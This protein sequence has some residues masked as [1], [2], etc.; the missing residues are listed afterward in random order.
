M[1]KSTILFLE[2]LTILAFVFTACEL[3]P[4]ES[5]VEV[6]FF[7]PYLTADSNNPSRA[8]SS[9]SSGTS[10][11]FTCVFEHEN[12]R[13]FSL[14][15]NSGQTL[16]TGKI[17]AGKWSITLEAFNGSTREYSAA[18]K[19]TLA[20]NV[21]QTLVFSFTKPNGSGNNSGNSGDIPLSGGEADINF[22][23]AIS[24]RT[25]VSILKVSLDGIDDIYLSDSS[26]K[27]YNENQNIVSS[28]NIPENIT[29]EENKIV[30]LPVSLSKGTYTVSLFQGTRRRFIS[31]T[32]TVYPVSTITSVYIPNASQS[33]ASNVLPVTISGTNLTSID[34]KQNL[35]TI[36]GDITVLSNI[37]VIDDSKITATII[38]PSNEI[39]E[40][41]NITVTY[42]NQ[43]SISTSF[44]VYDDEK[45]F[46]NVG[47]FLLN[48]GTRIEY[49]DG[50]T[51]TSE[52][53]EKVIAIVGAKLY[54]G[55]TI[56]AT[57]INLSPTSLSLENNHGSFSYEG[58]TSAATFNNSTYTITGD[59]QG[60]DNLEYI[61][62]QDENGITDFE[63]NYPAFYYT[64]NYG[65]EQN[66]SG[67]YKKNWY[68]PSIYE[69]SEIMKNAAI[70]ENA[71]VAIDKSKF[72]RS[73]SKTQ[74]NSGTSSA[75]YNYYHYFYIL[76]SSYADNNNIFVT[77]VS[78]T[79]PE[80]TSYS[81]SKFDSTCKVPQSTTNYNSLSYTTNI[82]PFT[83]DAFKGSYSNSTGM[84]NY[85]YY[86]TINVLP[87]HIVP[88]N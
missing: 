17:P 41:Q 32:I 66:L 44:H 67:E 54:G 7:L 63:T 37:T 60:N 2:V 48:D 16:N 82:S 62:T 70:L 47:D 21:T 40:I 77:S 27:L 18:T 22:T 74:N 19:I 26:L 5:T 9:T 38:C 6:E 28:I 4:H 46:Y 42:N 65:I 45:C 86:Y 29:T 11:S 31:K 83:G 3:Q 35:L 85:I 33:Y 69:L 81:I 34:F 88:I 24:I 23:E 68:V 75:K 20:P 13:N 79:T 12:G 84:G 58:L 55:G 10:Y 72:G 80:T 59:L 71:R 53:K 8:V 15:G 76:S 43:F 73:E 52:Q 56:I 61:L 36:S 49:V 14:N 30:S 51:L 78:D 57:G 39:S 25:D 87:V 50:I 64:D 1:K